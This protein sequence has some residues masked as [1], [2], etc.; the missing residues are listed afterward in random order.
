M[1]RLALSVA[2]A[3]AIRR[4][5]MQALGDFFASPVPTPGGPQPAGPDGGGW[6]TMRATVEA[7][8]VIARR[9][10]DAGRGAD[11]GVVTI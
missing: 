1:L 4:I 9:G 8:I 10:C 2:M 5:R 3:P 6:I 7:V 11:G